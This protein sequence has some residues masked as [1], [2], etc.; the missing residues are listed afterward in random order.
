MPVARWRE[1]PATVI[2]EW[3]LDPRTPGELA[4]AWADGA[5]EPGDR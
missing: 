3:V 2:P 5:F 1:Q 4:Q